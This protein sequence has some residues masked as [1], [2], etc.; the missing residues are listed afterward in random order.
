MDGKD[1]ERLSRRARE[2][3]VESVDVRGRVLAALAQPRRAASPDRT[4]L[5]F[6]AASLAAA[7]A[8]AII[9]LPVFE[10]LEEPLAG[11][12]AGAGLG[13]R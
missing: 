7:A 8:M 11:L 2:E 1:L 13:P 6:A 3:R 10:A 12:F 9:A 4:L 5:A